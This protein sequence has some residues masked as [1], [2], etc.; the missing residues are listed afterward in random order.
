ML[1]ANY[2]QLVNGTRVLDIRVQQDC[3]VC[4]GILLTYGVDVVIR[5]RDVKRF[6][7]E[8]IS[9]II[10]REIRTKYGH[11][12]LPGSDKYLVEEL[13]DYLI[14]LDEAVFKKIVGVLPRFFTSS[15]E[16]HLCLETKPVRGPETRRSPLECRYLRDNYWINIRL[17]LT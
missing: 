1:N 4:H 3:R 2:E 13:G 6:L 5:D 12:D 14:P 8:T 15:E 11:T 16:D 17:P 10:I 7:P 9:E